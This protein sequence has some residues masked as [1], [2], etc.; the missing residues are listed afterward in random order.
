VSAAI[1]ERGLV[2]SRDLIGG[3]AQAFRRD[4]GSLRTA[5]DHRSGER[6]HQA[7]RQHYDRSF[8]RLLPS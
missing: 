6:E 3:C 4:R 5:A 7:A 1:D 8:H 2:D